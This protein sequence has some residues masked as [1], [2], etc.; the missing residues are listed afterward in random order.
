ME[1]NIPLNWRPWKQTA[2]PSSHKQAAVHLPLGRILASGSVDLDQVDGSLWQHHEQVEPRMKKPPRQS[3]RSTV[4]RVWEAKAQF[5]RDL[6]F[7]VTT[8]ATTQSNC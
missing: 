4:L 3:V 1:A 2:A 6:T 8:R 5:S 7:C